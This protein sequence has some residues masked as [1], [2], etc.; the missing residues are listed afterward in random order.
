MLSVLPGLPLD[1]GRIVRA[2]AWARTGDAGGRPAW[3][4]RWAGSTG[5]ILAGLGIFVAL[6][7]E[8][9]RPA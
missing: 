2:I 3:P 6:T 8:P 4:R 9:A 1:G 7:A 5:W